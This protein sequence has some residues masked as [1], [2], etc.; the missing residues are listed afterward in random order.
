MSPEDGGMEAGAVVAG[1]GAFDLDGRVGEGRVD[2][3]VGGGDHVGGRAENRGEID[4]NEDKMVVRRWFSRS[5]T[6]T[7]D[8]KESKAS[9]GVSC[10]TLG[11]AYETIP[12][13][14]REEHRR[15]E[16]L[17]SGNQKPS[18]HGKIRANLVASL[19]FYFIFSFFCMTT[20][21][22]SDTRDRPPK[23]SD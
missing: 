4:E 14:I 10:T 5:S 17:R 11:L 20:P 21:P 19:V 3:A 9:K 8:W 2:V 15:S 7:R 16:D 12:C 18:K 23:C 1:E 6:A 13:R 22:K